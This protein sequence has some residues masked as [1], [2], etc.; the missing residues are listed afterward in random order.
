MGLTYANATI[1]GLSQEAVAAYLTSRGRNAFVSP[2]INGLTVI[3]HDDFDD[4]FEYAADFSRQFSCPAL[5]V[6]EFDDDL[7]NY[8]LYDAGR[9]ID[10][11][12]S[13]PAY[14]DDSKD[15]APSGG[16]AQKLC[17]AFG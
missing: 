17:A 5:V 13:F 9:L 4:D 16:D 10:D 3:Y 12:D 8:Q 6:Y 15:P 14:F 7:L 1:K 2:T 11:Y